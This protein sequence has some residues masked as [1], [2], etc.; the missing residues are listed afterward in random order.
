MFKFR[1]IAAIAA[2]VAS[3]AVS[4]TAQAE[5]L[6]TPKTSFAVCDATHI[7]Y[8]V[9]AVSVKAIGG[10]EEPLTFTAT[11]TELTGNAPLN[12]SLTPGFAGNTNL[13]GV[14][15]SATWG[16]NGHADAGYDGIYVDAKA[17][18]AFSN[19]LTI[20]VRPVF[21]DAATKTMKNA[22][23]AAGST[24]AQNLNLN[25][26]V[27]VKVRTGLFKSGV[28]IGIAT[29]YSTVQSSDSNG[30]ILTITAT[31]VEVPMATAS[32]Q[33]TGETGKA[34]YKANQIMI[35]YAPTNDPTGGFGVEGMTG[36]MS[37]ATNGACS[38]S[39]PVWDSAAGEVKWTVA[40]P[41][42]APDGTTI[43]KGFYKAVIPEVDAGLLWG[44][45]DIKQA[46]KALVVSI[47][48]EGGEQST[49]IN[50]IAVKNKAIYIEAS[51][52]QYS[53]PTIKIKKNTKFKGFAKK[54][55][56][57]CTKAGKTIT[58]KGYVCPAGYA[59]KK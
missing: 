1:A 58:Y 49:A 42:F 22:V 36:G 55:T 12:P 31:P 53:K 23:A 38:A 9:E 5:D 52:F 14:W 10:V 43:N 30:N 18:N 13:A 7:T 59:K 8:C 27:T 45:T 26:S 56:L 25:E 54:T 17:A 51:G 40:A 32:S 47:T 19:F 46:A 29:T 3:F 50:S 24:A 41:H 6:V 33:C 34:T 35:T 39:T 44:L 28:S 11:G 48:E 4:T 21:Y 2:L 57:K 16:A 37:V 15:S 20:N